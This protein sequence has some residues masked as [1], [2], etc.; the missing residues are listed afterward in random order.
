MD[1][2]YIF[3]IEDKSGR[4]I[5]LSKERWNQHIRP[6]HPDIRDSEELMKALQNPDKIIESDRDEV[7]RW[8]F[9]YDKQKRKYL[10]ISVKYLN[11]DGY[12]ITAHYTRKIW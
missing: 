9:L 10:K 12:V 11:G 3:E 4:L 7:V 1:I 2:N 5:H 8:Y 6:L